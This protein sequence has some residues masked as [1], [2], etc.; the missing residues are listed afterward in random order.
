[1][2]LCG[3]PS[4]FINELASHGAMPALLHIVEDG[5]GP[6]GAARRTRQVFIKLGECFAEIRRVQ[7]GLRF[8]TGQHSLPT[9]RPV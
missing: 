3:A 8:F 9:F 7:Q 2:G 1:M 6:K 5:A 4:H